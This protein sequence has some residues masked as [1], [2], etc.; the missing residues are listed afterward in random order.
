[1]SSGECSFFTES[2]SARNVAVSGDVTTRQPSTYMNSL[3]VSSIVLYPVKYLPERNV[4]RTG[5]MSEL[6]CRTTGCMVT[7]T[8]KILP[9]QS[10]IIIFSWK[11]GNKI[12]RGHVIK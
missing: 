7:A 5:G 8:P 6:S 1:M 11:L 3:S 9:D 12:P 10:V 2:F 4:L